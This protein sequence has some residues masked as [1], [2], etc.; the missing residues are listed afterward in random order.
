ML[1]VVAALIEH[2]GNLLVCQRRRGHKFELMWEFPGGKM[3]PGESPKQALERELREE[4]SLVAQ[5]GE[6]VHRTRHHYP[7]MYEPLDLIFFSARAQPWAIENRVFE[8]VQWRDP[9]SLLE[10]NFLP[11]D[12]ELVEQLAAGRLRL[13]PEDPGKT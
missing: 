10:L 13:P 5:I 4:L 1:T 11:A 3:E 8:Q 12:Q 6:P 2:D 9:R 7:D